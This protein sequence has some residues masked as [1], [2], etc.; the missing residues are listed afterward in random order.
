MKIK[1]A[2][3]ALPDLYFQIYNKFHQ[4]DALSLRLYMEA[5]SPPESLVR[6]L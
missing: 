6:G 3:V 5:A 2:C 1:D 4:A